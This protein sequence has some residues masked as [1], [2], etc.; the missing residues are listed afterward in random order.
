VTGKTLALIPARGGSKRLPGKNVRPFL[1]RPLIHWSIGFAQS[2]PMFDRVLVSTDSPEI[3]ECARAAGLD[4]PWLRPAE[5]ATDTATSVDVALD[6]LRR[7]REQGREYEF[8][9]LL[10]PTTPMR[11]PRRWQDAADLMRARSCNAVIGVSPVRDHP[12]QVFDMAPDGSLRPW[13]DGAAV[14]ARSQDLPP[15]VR[16]NGSLYLVR[17][18]VLE[19]QRSFFPSATCAIVCS[20]AWEQADIDTEADWIMAEAL[21]RHRQEQTT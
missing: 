9:A 6:V 14:Q 12:H 8:L 5:I 19:S 4:I 21:A 2:Q 11:D 20:E 13:A 18:A 10:Q 1:G 15:A 17:T 16:V 7:E 3:A